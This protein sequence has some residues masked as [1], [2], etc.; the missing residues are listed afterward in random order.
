[1]KK[2]GFL[3]VEAV[4]IVTMTFLMLSVLMGFA[5]VIYQQT[6]IVVTANDAASKIASVYSI[7]QAD[8]FTGYRSLDDINST[9]IYRY[10]FEDSAF[11]GLR[12]PLSTTNREKAEWLALA[13]MNQ[14]AIIKAK[15]Q[16][17]EVEVEP[18]P[19]MV[20][21]SHIVTVRL[22]QT[23]D[24]PGAFAFQFFGVER[25]A[26]FTATGTAVA[27]D[28]MHRMNTVDTQI[29]ALQYVE[30]N[31]FGLKSAKAVADTV[32]QMADTLTSWL[33]LL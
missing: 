19:N 8:P 12:E 7:P 13:Q 27:N 5:F 33:K 29:D 28:M 4:F 17:W 25:E 1:M 22:T 9:P 20:G 14:S 26:V 6:N 10:M 15:N 2:D 11:F 24:V 21:G 23:Y 16:E 3:M 18:R 30:D 31:L 32:K